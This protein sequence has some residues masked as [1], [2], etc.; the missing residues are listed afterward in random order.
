MADTH[1]KIKELSRLIE[2]GKKR[3]NFKVDTMFEDQNDKYE[4]L[5][6]KR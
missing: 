1:K 5:L 3:V 6:K 2:E 4:K